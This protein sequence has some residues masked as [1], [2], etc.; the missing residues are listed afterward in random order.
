MTGKELVMRGIAEA[1]IAGQ[2][3]TAFP[4]GEP[5]TIRLTRDGDR[6]VEFDG[7][8]IGA[9]ADN[10]SPEDRR[11]AVAIYA[12]VGGKIVTQ[13]RRVG[14]WNTDAVGVHASGEDALAWLKADNDGELGAVSKAAWATACASHSLLVDLECERVA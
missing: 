6:D 12:T 1:M 4:R 3:G 11:L 7:W 13:R 14:N 8:V 10:V 2:K 9:A 5:E